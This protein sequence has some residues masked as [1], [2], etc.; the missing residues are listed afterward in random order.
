MSSPI[1]ALGLF[2]LGLLS[3][4]LLAYTVRP[5]FSVLESLG[6][7]EHKGN[8]IE[9]T[10]KVSPAAILKYGLPNPISD[11]AIR[12]GFVS[13][14]DRRMRNPA[15]VAEHL[16]P[17]KLD[18][19][20]GNR[21][22]S[23]FVEDDSIPP[24]F[25]AKL[26]D[27][28]RSG[29]DRGHQVPAAD[30]KFTQEAMD[31]TFY[32][33]N[34]CPQV[35]DGF[36]RDYWA[37]FEDFCRRLTKQYK[38]VRIITGPLYLP[39]QYPDGKWRVTY[40]VIGSPANVAVPTHF[41]KVIVADQGNFEDT[42]AVAAFVLP[43]DVIPNETNLSSF[44]VPIDAVERASGLELL[45]SLPPNKR[46]NL[47]QMTDCSILVKFFDNNRQKRLPAPK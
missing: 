6:H 38:S 39:K 8:S 27:Y 14:Y 5:K 25:R 45:P 20:E 12:Q 15:W 29:Y 24:K 47:C 28:L 19:R 2:S 9:S 31:E 11:V 13:C 33:T 21:S 41:Y 1:N 16:T 32:L 36:N 18:A 30:C 7:L 3:G 44:L 43:N 17:A 40:E 10:T 34:I 37:H 23:V 35:G 42:P 22:K 4:G 26:I 46:N